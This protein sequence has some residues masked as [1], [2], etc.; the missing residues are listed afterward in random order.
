MAFLLPKGYRF[1]GVHCDVKPNTTKLDLS[2]IVSDRPATAAG[3]Y[4]QNL[5]CGAPVQLDRLRTPGAGFRAIVVNSGVANACTGEQGFQNA[6]TMAALTAEAI[7]AA[8]D[9]TLVMS[10]GV[11]GI[12]LPMNKIEAGIKEAASKLSSSYEHFN[13]AASGMMTTDT[14][15]KTASRSLT[16]S[17]GKTIVLCGMGK[18]AAMIG[19][20]MATMLVVLITDAALDP[21]DAQT[22]LKRVADETFNCI[23]VEGHTSTSDTVLFLA[24]GAAESSPLKDQDQELLAAALKDLC[25]ELAQMIP[26]DGEGVSHLIT[27]DVYGCKDRESAKTIAKTV[28]NDAL[29]KTAICG[30]DP[31]WGRIVSAAGRTGVSFDP[32]KV[33]LKINGFDLY[34]NG[35]PLP[36]DKQTVSQSIRDNRKTHFELFFQEGEASIRFWTSDLTAEYVHLNADY[37]T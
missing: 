31:N 2:L 9:Q 30:A 23:S 3:V 13:L 34:Q 19:P 6:E 20:N 29:V 36:F 11:I 5:V 7:G 32:M 8:Q 25:A 24:N 16:L 33:S 37:T 22:M 35:T 17:N 15:R 26:N 1:A 18:G 28:A 27:I 12:Q 14:V 21:G 10:T 4:T